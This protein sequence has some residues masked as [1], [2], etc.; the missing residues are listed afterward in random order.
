MEASLIL[1]TFQRPDKLHNCLRS[2]A[3]QTTDCF[4]VLVG[5]D[6]PD[7]RGV[8]AA[9]KACPESLRARLRLIEC[10]RSGLTAVR[11]SILRQARGRLMIST[12]DDVV[13]EPGFVAAH[14]AGH[15]ERPQRC[16]VIVGASPWKVHQ[17]DRLFD[18]LI[19]ETSMVFFY[20]VMDTHESLAQREKDWGF[21]HCWGLNFSAPMD[22]VR[23]VGCFT[24]FPA[25]YGYEDNEIAF[26]LKERYGAPVLYR[27]EARLM[28][29]HRMEPDAYLRREFSLGYEALGFAQTSPACARALF[30]RDVH[31]P[32]ELSY[33]REYIARERA[34][35]ARAL[36]PFRALAALS[37][38]RLEGPGADTLR[39]MAYQHHLPLKRWMWRA[40]L[41]AAAEGRDAAAVE[42]PG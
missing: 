26:K 14:I 12:N 16:T 37:S 22:A 17:P 25:W 20:G 30:G 3:A 31:A 4:E 39:D 2:L 9:H 42:L 18:R 38:T 1:P 8:E 21:R 24:V 33:S 28:H 34:A 36:A 32:P 35:A 15:A 27:P 29:D 19:R 11:N 41:V 7:P 23:E 10:P 5:F 40:G 6:G 13:P